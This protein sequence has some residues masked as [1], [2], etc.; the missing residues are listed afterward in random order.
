[1]G[2]TAAQVAQTLVCSPR[3]EPVCQNRERQRPD[4]DKPRDNEGLVF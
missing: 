1:M 3:R 2:C 4:Q